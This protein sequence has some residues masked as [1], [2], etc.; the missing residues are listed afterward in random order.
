MSQAPQDARML[1]VGALALL[2]VGVFL[3]VR[4]ERAMTAVLGGQAQAQVKPDETAAQWAA[5]AKQVRDQNALLAQPP[6]RRDPFREAPAEVRE[7]GA[8]ETGPRPPARPATPA[9][10]AVLFDNVNPSVKLRTSSATSDWLHVGDKF[11]GWTVVS[12]SG[13]AVEI[14]QGGERVVLQRR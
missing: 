5:L 8:R 7:S 13:S 14:S 1:W 3:G 12:I 6:G 9:I 11:A 2:M 4:T 10:A